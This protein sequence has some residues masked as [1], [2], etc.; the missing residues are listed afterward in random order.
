MSIVR[1]GLMTG[2]MAET[3]FSLR[4]ATCKESSSM[5]RSRETEMKSSTAL[6][7]MVA[8]AAVIAI[9][10]LLSINSPQARAYPKP[11]INKISWELDFRHGVPSRITVQTKGSDVPKAYWYMPFT[12]TNNT[13]DE[14]EFLPL[15]ELVDDRGNVHRSDQNISPEVFEAIKAREGKKLM[16]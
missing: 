4:V 2:S 13:K 12:V 11:S 14:Q 8:P 5:P 3:I 7:S 16:E 1:P 15:F 9:A 10:V 6:D